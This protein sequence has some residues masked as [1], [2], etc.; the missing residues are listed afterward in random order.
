MLVSLDCRAPGASEGARSSGC[1]VYKPGELGTRGGGEF[2]APTSRRLFVPGVP[3]APGDFAG[4]DKEITSFPHAR[5]VAPNAASFGVLLGLHPEHRCAPAS[6]D[7][8]EMLL[9]FQYPLT[10]RRVTGWGLPGV[11]RAIV[12]GPEPLRA[13][14]PRPSV[15]CPAP[16]LLRTPAPP[17][18]GRA[19]GAGW[20]PLSP[21]GSAPPR[22]A[23]LVTTPS[24]APRSGTAPRYPHVALPSG[25][26]WGLQVWHPRTHFFQVGFVKRQKRRKRPSIDRE[27]RLG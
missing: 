2:K 13:V 17:L 7:D 4:T 11:P 5:D 10:P 14:L 19:P 24:P 23:Q 3:V 8:R 18:A 6:A 25:C 9:T 12:R 16:Y 15:P 1:P 22:P 27:R 20:P 26:S 21:T